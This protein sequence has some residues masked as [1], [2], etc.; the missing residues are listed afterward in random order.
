MTDMTNYLENAFLNHMLRNVALSSPVTVYLALFNTPTTDAGGGTEVSGV[1]YARQSVT[2]GAPSDGITTNSVKITFPAA[3]AG[4]WGIVTHG[5][6]FDAVS[7][8]NMLYHGPF[9]EETIVPQGRTV[10]I[11]VNDLTVKNF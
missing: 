5:A 9:N 6:I 10:E 7:S 3:G 2:F 4:G 8:G 11:P 1:S